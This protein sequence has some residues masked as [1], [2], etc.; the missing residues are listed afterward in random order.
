MEPIYLQIISHFQ[1]HTGYN[2]HA[3]EFTKA[4]EAVAAAGRQIT[5]LRTSATDPVELQERLAFLGSIADSSQVVNICLSYGSL[6]WKLL[7]PFPGLKIA[8]TVWESTHLPDDWIEPLRCCDYVWTASQWGAE[9]FVQNGLDPARV[10]VV[11]EGVDTTLFYPEQQPHGQLAQIP[12]FKFFTVGKCETRKSTVEL[13]RAFDLEFANEPGVMMLL[14]TENPFIPGFEMKNFVANLWL[15]NPRKFIYAPKGQTHEQVAQMVAACDCGVFPTKAEGWGLPILESMAAGKPTIATHYSAVTEYAN[16]Y[17]AVLLDYSLVPVDG[18]FFDRADKDYGLWAMPNVLTLRRKMREV[19]EQRTLYRDRFRA[20][21]PTTGENWSWQAS[22][23]K[24]WQWLEQTLYPSNTGAATSM[25]EPKP[26][27]LELFDRNYKPKIGVRAN[28]FRQ[29]F[30]YLESRQKSSYTIVETGCARVK[31]NWAGDGQS[32]VMF[33][34]FVNHY[35]GRVF[36]VDINRES[37]ES[38]QTRVTPKTQ[39][40]CSDSVPFLWK[41]SQQGDLD[42]DLLYLDSYDVDWQNPHP[43]CL[44]HMK[45]LC[46]IMPL[47]KPGTLVV[48]DDSVKAIGVLPNPPKEDGTMGFTPIKDL[49]VMGKGTYVDNFFRNI[50][51]QRVIDGY[52]SGWIMPG[53]A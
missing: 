11:P 16:D 45:E 18:I 2:V 46:A 3:R 28:T 40:A 15:K 24:A 22:A 10:A 5:V 33:D 26:A 31:D 49:G 44:H 21:A 30:E 1:G 4:L 48:V 12:G 27:F 50:G 53:R 6:C 52:Q 29:I 41:L 19:Y 38:L 25:T 47:L 51:C 20:I 35:D 14:A 36:S 13:I 17:N 43:S 23:H 7:A 32:T 37:C 8:Y 42:I 34:H 39:I 9:V